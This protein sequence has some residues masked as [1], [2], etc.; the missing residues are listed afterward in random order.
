MYWYMIAPSKIQIIVIAKRLFSLVQCL[1]CDDGLASLDIK[2]GGNKIA[3]LRLWRNWISILRLFHFWPNKACCP[4]NI[5]CQWIISNE[6]HVIVHWVYFYRG[7][8]GQI[9][10]LI[11]AQRQ[12]PEA[13][14]QWDQWAFAGLLPCLFM[15]KFIENETKLNK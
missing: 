10:G 6:Q 7:Y 1:W 11:M 4:I 2:V 9:D 8:K 12:S 13:Q 14:Y 15:C 5:W 3:G